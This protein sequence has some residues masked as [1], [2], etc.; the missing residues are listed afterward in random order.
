MRLSVGYSTALRDR[1][2]LYSLYI[3]I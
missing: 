2:R 3:A 1:H